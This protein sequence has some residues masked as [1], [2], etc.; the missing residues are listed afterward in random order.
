MK[1]YRITKTQYAQD[2]KGTGAKLF[3]GRWNHIDSPCIYTA[4]SRALSI[5]EYAVNA[6]VDFIPRA[7][8]ICIF[9]I[10]ENEIYSLKEED[11]PGNW[12]ETP[13]PKSTKDL[14][15]RLLKEKQ[16]ILKI[17]SIIIPQEFNYILNPL[18][19]YP[20]FKLLETRDFIFD[21]RIKMNKESS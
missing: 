8:S 13:A 14:G 2:L 3:G 11:L 17:P 10:E 6:N 19:E 4:G 20:N 16:S 7:L 9:E 1:V 5:L 21:L 15:T 18:M 12:R